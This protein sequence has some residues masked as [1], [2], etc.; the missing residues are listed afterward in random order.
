MGLIKFKGRLSASV[1]TP[2]AGYGTI[3]YDTAL[4][5]YCQIDEDGTITAL[6]VSA[7]GLS[8]IVDD[9]TPQLGGDLDL[10]GKGLDFP[11]TANISDCLDEDT[12]SS[13]SATALAT[14]QSIKA[15]VDTNAGISDV[16]DDTTP[17][18][19]GDL[20]LNG[21]NIDF[22]STA[23]ISDCLDEDDM[24]SDSSTS[25]ATQQ[26]IKAYVDA[27]VSTY[28]NFWVDAAAMVP[29]TTNGA[30]ATTTEH[31]TNDIEI[32]S[33]AFDA[34]TEEGVQF[35]MTMPDN[36]D[37]GTIK[38]KVYWDAKATASGTAVWGISAG[39]LGDSD[40]IDTALGTEITTTDTL[41]TVGDNHI[42]PA[43]TAITIAG[44]PAL[45]ELCIFQVVCKTS[46]TIAVDT[47]LMGISIQYS[48]LSTAT[49]QW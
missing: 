34:S 25:L 46:G 3:F 19:G 26:S 4:K 15:Y 14:Q 2:A 44:S 42:A 13:D 18:L 35:K 32:D 36:W 10:N 12:M 24:S 9:V 40:V 47:L 33:Y 37:L 5:S 45:G 20:D 49:A 6:N 28:E 1:D 41:L 43:T 22:P 7:T 30:E 21:N 23:N 38:V 8:D 39:A 17:Q 48:K 16:V 11:T 27:K 29:R 31:G